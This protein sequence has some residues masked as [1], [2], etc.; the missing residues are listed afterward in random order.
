M[1]AQ[2]VC[3]KV[4]A[5]GHPRPRR[6]LTTAA[7]RRGRPL[8]ELLRR[9]QLHNA[10]RPS[11]YIF[12]IDSLAKRKRQLAEITASP[13]MVPAK[14][15]PTTE[16]SLLNNV[17]IRTGLCDGCLCF[18]ETGFE[19]QRKRRGNSLVFS[20]AAF[21]DKAIAQKAA[22]TALFT[23]LRE[24]SRFERVSG[25]GRSRYRTCIRIPCG[26]EQGILQFRGDFAHQTTS[27]VISGLF[28]QVPY[29]ANREFLGK[30][31]GI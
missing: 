14:R 23:V 31:Q 22:N 24:I 10:S 28:L 4:F 21:R 19:T 12:Q 5:S 8:W 27:P 16:A 26:K 25:G 18:R 20:L 2:T 11:T 15:Q 13:E 29:A 7:S 30:E 1:C 6:V 17:T 9:V 3:A